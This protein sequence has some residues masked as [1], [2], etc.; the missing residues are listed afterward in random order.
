[1]Y[2]DGMPEEAFRFYGISLL[3]QVADDWD[4]RADEFERLERL[5]DELSPARLIRRYRWGAALLRGRA[6]RMELEPY[7]E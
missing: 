3:R 6:R 4:K 5:P 1:M 2:A 7:V